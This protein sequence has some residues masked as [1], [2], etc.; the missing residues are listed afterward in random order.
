[1]HGFAVRIRAESH[2]RSRNPI[3]VAILHARSINNLL[4]QALLR[5]R[6]GIRRFVLVKLDSEERLRK[7]AFASQLKST[8]K[9][10][11]K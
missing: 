4:D 3:R 6:D 8:I 7:R 11:L 10:L 9:Q 2:L 1:M 5:E